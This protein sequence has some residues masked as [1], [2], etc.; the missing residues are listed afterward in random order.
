[1]ESHLYSFLLGVLGKGKMHFSQQ[2]SWIQHPDFSNFSK[3]QK[4]QE[5]TVSNGPQ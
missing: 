4:I 3:S 2:K 5:Q 1:M